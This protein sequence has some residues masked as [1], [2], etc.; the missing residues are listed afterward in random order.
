MPS[1]SWSVARSEVTSLVSLGRCITQPHH[2]D[3]ARVAFNLSN[4]HHSITL[5]SSGYLDQP[6][7]IVRIPLQ[8]I[9]ST[10]SIGE[11]DEDTQ[12]V[13]LV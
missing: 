1:Q 4:P 5:A 6:S 12:L 3:T 11:L 9:L 7:S 10:R 13:K 2:R 8:L